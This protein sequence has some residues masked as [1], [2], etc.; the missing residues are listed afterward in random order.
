MTIQVELSPELA[1]SLA[2]EA[3]L[4]GMDLSRYAQKVLGER[5]PVVAPRPRALSVEE[6]R[7]LSGLFSAG[8]ENLPVLP[9]EV[10]NRESYYEDRR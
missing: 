9:L 5:R 1:T 10:N 6:V 8:S 3:R 2:A 7:A 4:L